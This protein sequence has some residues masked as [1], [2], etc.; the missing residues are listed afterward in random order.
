MPHSYLYLF[1][2][3]AHGDVLVANRYDSNVLTNA[4]NA[5]NGGYGLP[6]TNV[7]GQHRLAPLIKSSSTK[8]SPA[9]R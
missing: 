7:A 5:I 1:A 2:A 9:S 8:T 3:T 6:A 4:T